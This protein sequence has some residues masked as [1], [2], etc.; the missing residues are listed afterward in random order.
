MQ[1]PSKLTASEAA[2]LIRGGRLHPADLMESCLARI[3]EREGAVR[4]FAWFDPATACRAATAARP[5]KLHGLPIGVKDVL[6]TTDMPSEYG[7]PVLGWW[8]PRRR[9]AAAAL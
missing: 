3:A 6:D 2:R 1:E 8:R 7:S 5:G 4:A 9:H